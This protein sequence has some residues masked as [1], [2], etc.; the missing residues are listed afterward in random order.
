MIANRVPLLLSILRMFANQT[1]PLYW[2]ITTIR[3]LPSYHLVL[4]LRLF[5]SLCYDHAILTK[6][7]SSRDG[8]NRHTTPSG[9]APVSLSLNLAL[10]PLPFIDDEYI[11]SSFWPICFTQSTKRIINYARPETSTR[12]L[13][14]HT[15]LETGDCNPGFEECKSGVLS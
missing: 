8:C 15:M 3:C 1:W 9:Y 11:S 14:F 6:Y 4:H 7:S 5:H 12:I 13:A 2:S 10:G